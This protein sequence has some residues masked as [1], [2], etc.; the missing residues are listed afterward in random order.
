MYYIN[1][2][3][4]LPKNIIHLLY[5]FTTLKLRHLIVCESCTNLSVSIDSLYDTLISIRLLCALTD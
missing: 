1:K 3:L 2:K 5:I 4:Q